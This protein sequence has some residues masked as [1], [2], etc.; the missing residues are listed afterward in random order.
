MGSTKKQRNLNIYSSEHG[1]NLIELLVVISV[2]ALIASA[3]LLLINSSRTKSRDAR[4]VSDVKQLSSAL[5]LYYSNCNSYPIETDAPLGTAGQYTT[6][7]TGTGSVLGPCG[8]HNG[9]STQ[10]G[11]FGTNT[12]GTVL[13]RTINPPPSPGDGSC[14]GT[15]DNTYLYNS[16]GSSYTLR[17]CL[18]NATSGYPA[19]LNTITR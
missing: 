17:F 4:R 10:N 18:G 11:G 16:S 15:N 7:Y 3:A 5:D 6:L 8:A 1:F 2:I 13:I 9:S 12:T 19:G 14:T